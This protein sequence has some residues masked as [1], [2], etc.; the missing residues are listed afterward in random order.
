MLVL[1]IPRRST[2][3]FATIEIPLYHRVHLALAGG[4]HVYGCLLAGHNE[5]HL[6]ELVIAPFDFNIWDQLWRL[7]VSVRDRV[8]VV[9][10]VAEAV[11]RFDANILAAETATMEEQ[12]LYHIEMVIQVHDRQVVDR[13]ERA[14]LTEFLDEIAFLHDRSPRLKVRSMHNL[15][16]TKQAFTKQILTNRPFAPMAGKIQV[17]WTDEIPFKPRAV[18]L[19]V[20]LEFRKI[21]KEFVR[22]STPQKSDDDGFFLRL[23]DTKDR[24]LRV[25]FFRANDPVI[26]T[27]ME[28]ADEVGAAA[29]IFGA[30]RRSGFNILT[31][32]LTPA[33]QEDRAQSEVV[34]RLDKL[35]GCSIDALKD[36]VEQAL[37]AMP[38]CDA[39]NIEIGYPD[40]Y[41]RQWKK[42]KIVPQVS[43]A[44]IDEPNSL[45]WSS[46][47]GTKLYAAHRE[48]TTLHDSGQVFS[49]TL[50]NRWILANRLRSRLEEEEQI[51]TGSLLPRILFVS[52][53]FKG[54]QLKVIHDAAKRHN[55]SVKTGEDLLNYSSIL[56]GL[57]SLMDGCTHFLG[58]WLR[59]GAL[60]LG[61][62]FWPSP[63]LHWE[64]GVAQAL[65]LVYRLLIHE[66]IAVAAWQRIAPGKQHVMFN[67]LN[68]AGQLDKVLRSLMN[69][70]PT[71][72]PF[73]VAAKRPPVADV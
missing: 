61:D 12:N 16:R 24:F 22:Q 41:A 51:P 6:P 2:Q 53:H 20:P 65:G 70:R 54:D 63:W 5:P 52:C 50:Q 11:R 43:S 55:F 32:F 44:S 18:K 64:F 1:D 58:A 49:E 59:Y 48:L 26:H 37:A 38:Q 73:L 15:S 19:R 21:L 31:A 46:Q 8:G 33:A 45:E 69:D 39:L 27:R 9:H 14:L 60:K 71:R 7:T 17:E 30:L 13:L 35:A 40:K 42:T 10:D 28:Y 36:A 3:N 67:D 66:D 23:S 25:L 47:L 56:S 62:E 72:T 29:A 57:P 34:V 68:F 4:G